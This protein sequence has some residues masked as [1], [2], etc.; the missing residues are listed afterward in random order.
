MRLHGVELGEGRGTFHRASYADCAGT[1]GVRISE[2]LLHAEALQ[3]AGNEGRIEAVAGP[4]GVQFFHE[5]AG[6][7]HSAI[8]VVVGGSGHA[9]LDHYGGDPQ[10]Q[11]FADRGLRG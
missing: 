11:D 1:A 4:G 6:S 8:C 2:A 5:K 10:V 9:V 7:A 3:P